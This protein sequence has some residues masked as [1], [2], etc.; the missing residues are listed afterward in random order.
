MIESSVRN[1]EYPH[2]RVESSLPE[3]SEAGESA[4]LDDD[5]DMEES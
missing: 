1:S 5:E 2:D 3:I 4:V